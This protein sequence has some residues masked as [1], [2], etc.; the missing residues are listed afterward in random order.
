[1]VVATSFYKKSVVLNNP[2]LTAKT[3]QSIADIYG[4]QHVIPLYGV[5]PDNRGDD[6]S[7]FQERVP[8]VYFFLGGSNYKQGI[9][10]MPHAPNFAVDEACIKTGVQFFSSMLVERLKK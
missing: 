9:I 2:A 7:Y 5:M 4:K 1:M 6:F 10:S 8:G 3:S